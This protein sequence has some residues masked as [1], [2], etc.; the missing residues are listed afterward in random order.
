MPSEARSFLLPWVFTVIW[1]YFVILTSD[2]A[3]LAD[4]SVCLNDRSFERIFLRISKLYRLSKSGKKLLEEASF[5]PT[6]LLLSIRQNV[7]YSLCYPL[8][9]RW[10]THELGAATTPRCIIWRISGRQFENKKKRTYRDIFVNTWSLQSARRTT[11]AL[12]A[13]FS[14]V[15]WTHTALDRHLVQINDE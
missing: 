12:L 6:N 11:F 2:T 8:G 4:K 9:P 3:F 10:V 14:F 7:L 1:P 5:H 15:L 13:A